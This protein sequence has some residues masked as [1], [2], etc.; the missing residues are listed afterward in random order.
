M[1]KKA[2]LFF[3]ALVM[4]T[5]VAWK[6]VEIEASYHSTGKVVPIELS[7]GR[8]E[9][10]EF[11]SKKATTRAIILFGSGD[12]GWSGFEE[13]ISIALQQHGYDVIGID[14]FNFAATDYD[15][16]TLQADYG[17]IAEKAEAKFGNDPRPLI[18]GGW[19]MGAEQAVAAGG[20]PNPP[21]RL[22]GLL[23]LDP[24]GRGRY[25]VRLSDRIN[26]LP[27]GP[28]TFSMDEFNRTM[29][30]RH[31]VQ[32][33]A[34]NDPIDSRQWLTGLTA[35]HREYD[36]ENTGHYYNNDREFFLNRLVGS[37]PWILDRDP[38]A[39]TTTGSKP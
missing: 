19:S 6:Y 7:R 28:G 29:G 11:P 27:T 4:T 30:G 35:P 8:F 13:E 16:A 26:M 25:G 34:Q 14:S 15:L 22:A 31:I 12:G 21:R 3:Y 24:C 18:I 37:I 2:S 33:H 39:V 32:W 5:V 38:D 20:G 36:F 17:K 9:L 23:L 10:L 1:L